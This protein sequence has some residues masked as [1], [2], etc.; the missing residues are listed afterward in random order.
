MRQVQVFKWEQQVIDG[1]RQGVRLP[2]FIGTFHQFGQEA[3]G[4]GQSNPVAIVESPDGQVHTVYASLMQF[5]PS[6]FR[7]MDPPAMLVASAAQVADELRKADRI[8]HVML[9]ALPADAKAKCAALLEEEGTSPDGMVRS[10]ER[11]AVL[12]AVG[13]L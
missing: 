5:L 1:C 13:V 7:P 4:E 6:K 8:I 11:R 2:D 9:N 12:A 3:D 10:N